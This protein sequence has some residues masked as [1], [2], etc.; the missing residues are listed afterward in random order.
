[1]SGFFLTGENYLL[2][3]KLVIPQLKYLALPA[4]LLVAELVH[5]TR[6][7]STLNSK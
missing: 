7:K 3:K 1:M 6:F 5:L 2:R 4:L